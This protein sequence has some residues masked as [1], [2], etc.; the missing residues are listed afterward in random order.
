MEDTIDVENYEN[1]E[2]CIVHGNIDHVLHRNGLFRLDAFSYSPG[3]CLF[4]A[5]HVL[6]HFAT[7]PLNCEMD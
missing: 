5:L 3:D 6:L 7:L 1:N 4:D 2:Q